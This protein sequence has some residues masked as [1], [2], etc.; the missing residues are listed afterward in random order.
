MGLHFSSLDWWAGLAGWFGGALLPIKNISTGLN[1]PIYTAK[2]TISRVL[3]DF[4]KHRGP[5]TVLIIH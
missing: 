4:G 5:Q 1:N 3:V 2:D